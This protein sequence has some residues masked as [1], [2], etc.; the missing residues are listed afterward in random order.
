MSRDKSS[1]IRAKNVCACFGKIAGA[2][3][4][5]QA[6][7][8]LVQRIIAVPPHAY[9]C[10]DGLGEINPSLVEESAEVTFDHDPVL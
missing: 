1:A 10:G 9:N 6:V 8:R 5:Q 2:E 7:R 3:V 4:S